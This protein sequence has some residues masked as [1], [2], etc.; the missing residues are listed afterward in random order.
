LKSNQRQLENV[1][2]ELYDVSNKVSEKAEAKS[3][4]VEI[5]INDLEASQQRAAIAEREVEALRDQI[6]IIQ[7]SANRY[8]R[9]ERF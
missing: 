8:F 2:S 6:R 1:Q 9:Y 7:D 4:E 3:D 5:M